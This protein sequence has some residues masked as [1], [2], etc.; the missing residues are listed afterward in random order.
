MALLRD[1]PFAEYG[2]RSG[3]VLASIL[4][5]WVCI[6]FTLFPVLICWSP[7]L[8]FDEGAGSILTQRKLC[9]GPRKPV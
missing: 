7:K 3:L 8:T 5:W 6:E 2:T 1:V 9:T 4:V